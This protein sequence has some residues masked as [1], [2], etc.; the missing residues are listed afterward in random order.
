MENE[1][2]PRIAGVNY[3]SMVDGEGVRAVIFL[4]GCAHN[5]P[6]CQN[7]KA[8]DPKFGAVCTEELIREIAEEIKARPFLSG[9]TL[10]GGDP[11]YDPGKTYSFLLHLFDA[12]G[13]ENGEH[14]DLWI[15][16]GYCLEKLEYMMEEDHFIAELL[17]YASHIVDGRFDE[18]RADKRL[19]F[20][21]SSNQLIFM[22]T[23]QNQLE[24]F[25]RYKNVT[26]SYDRGEKP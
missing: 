4:S 2:Y 22:N 24:Q 13:D 18:R 8:Q 3:E 17:R 14:T 7:W 20:R 5:C 9:I 15:Y 26:R 10:S 21:G 1:K 25:P 6:G 16:T 11:F 19:A 12:L 23:N